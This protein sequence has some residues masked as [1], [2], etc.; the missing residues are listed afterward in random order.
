MRNVGILI[1]D[2]VELLDFCGPHEAFTAVNYGGG[3]ALFTVFT[4][5]EKGGEVASRAGLRVIADYSF[6]DAPHIDVLVVPGGQ[7]T[8][9]EI[10]N[11]VVVDWI[12]KIAGSAELTTSVCTGSFLLAKAGTLPDGSR[13]TTHWGSIG[14]MRDMFPGIEVHENVRWID[15]GA[16][17][18]SAGVSAGID[19]S[20]HV[21][22]RLCGRAAAES[23]ART[24]EY[25]Y[26][27][28]ATAA[29]R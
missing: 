24:M 25:D 27:Q 10:D 6:D 1:F 23:S 2:G 14:R 7:G 16:V 17:V 29:T 28:P 21:I 18:S 5:A 4:V 19:M 15:D 9:R 11:P 26:W 12:A 22:E 20:L 8:R 3:N 13:A